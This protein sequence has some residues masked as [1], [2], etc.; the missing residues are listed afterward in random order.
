MDSS[1]V[2]RSS[3][4]RSWCDGTRERRENR[5][6]FWRSSLAYFLWCSA[7]L[8]RTKMN[9]YWILDWDEDLVSRNGLYSRKCLVNLG[10]EREEMEGSKSEWRMETRGK[11]ENRIVNTANNMKE[12]QP[13]KKRKREKKRRRR[14]IDETLRRKKIKEQQKKR[15]ACE[16]EDLRVGKTWFTSSIKNQCDRMI[17]E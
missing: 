12:K 2:R 7:S 14:T 8:P 1:F 6:T 17:D 11:E 9:T 15:T 5:G 10:W 4:K 13:I 3:L 16:M